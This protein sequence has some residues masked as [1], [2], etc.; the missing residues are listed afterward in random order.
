MVNIEKVKTYENV[1]ATSPI[2]SGSYQ[3][4]KATMAGICSRQTCRA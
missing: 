2:C 3:A 4:E 1:L